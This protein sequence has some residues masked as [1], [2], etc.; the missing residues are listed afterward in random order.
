MKISICHLYPDVL[1]LYG[2]QGNVTCLAKR[3]VWR[4]IDVEVTPLPIGEKADMTDF[5]IF[6]IGGGQDFEQG[7]LLEDLA[8]GKGR[9]IVSAIED[10]KVFLAVCGGYQLMGKSYTTHEGVQYD[11]LGAVDMCT[12]GCRERMIGDYMFT[13]SPESSGSDVVSFENHS[14]KTYLG[15]G[16]KPLGTVINGFGNNGEDGTEGVRYKNLL[17]TYGHGPLLPKNPRLADYI[18]SL[19]LERK[20]PGTVLPEL[21]DTFENNAHEVIAARL[22]K[23]K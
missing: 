10:E 2:D 9:E 12:I 17:G 3:L 5:D 14:G 11:F 22:G 6:F 1:N 16:V 15:T 13:C 8:A 4:N 23:V 7:L 19:A 21:D 18:L 20:Y